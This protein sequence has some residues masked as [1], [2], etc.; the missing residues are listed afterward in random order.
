MG[1]PVQK[2]IVPA[3]PDPFSRALGISSD[4][5]QDLPSVKHLSKVFQSID[6]TQPH[7]PSKPQPRPPLPAKPASL[8]IS[9]LSLSPPSRT[10]SDPRP[11]RISDIIIDPVDS[12]LDFSEIRAK[13]QS[14]ENP[15]VPLTRQKAS[16]SEPNPRMSR[17]TAAKTET[18][19][20]SVPDV[21][22]SRIPPPVP[23]KRWGRK[24]PE[25]ESPRAVSWTSPTVP[26]TGSFVAELSRRLEQAERMAEPVRQIIPA[27]P[28]PTKKILN[29]SLIIPPPST[30]RSSSLSTLRLPLPRS[31][32]GTSV[33]SMTSTSSNSSGTSR[34]AWPYGSAM[35]SWLSGSSSSDDLQLSIPSGHVTSSSSR[36]SLFPNMA[37]TAS[38]PSYP[39]DP[40]DLPPVSPDLLDSPELTT[41]PTKRARVVQ[42]I[43]ETERSYATDMRLIKE[44]YYDKASEPHSPLNPLDIKQIFSN[45]LD[46]LALESDFLP[47]LE[48]VCTE[49][50]DFDLHSR[51]K[52]NKTIGK[53]FRD[54]C[55]CIY[56]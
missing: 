22:T 41:R 20:R 54:M 7:S 11:G 4:H 33:N 12:L 29:D 24:A 19:R 2:P 32:T 3:R 46:I 31:T 51:N 26:R 55:C 45:L 39:S 14:I 15:K 42:E 53:L 23:P 16:L 18:S 36:R 1:S 25:E 21:P 49:E 37:L 38:P 9:T 27:S 34:R 35:A 52:T 28:R 30:H 13:F 10:Q 8:R 6:L 47:L 43:L 56:K 40:S 50:V 17:R 44:V 48:C 5:D